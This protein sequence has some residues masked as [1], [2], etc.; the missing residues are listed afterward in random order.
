M[1]RLSLALPWAAVVG[2]WAQL[3][4]RELSAAWVYGGVGACAVGCAIVGTRW[5]RGAPAW[6]SLWVLCALSLGMWAWT[7]WR[8]SAMERDRWG[9]DQGVRD[10]AVVATVEGLPVR[11]PQSLRFLLRIETAHVAGVPVRVPQ[12]VM[13]SWHG[14]GTQSMPLVQAGERWAMTLRLR[15]VHGA[16]NPHGFDRE[17]WLWQ[18]GVGATATVRSGGKDP[19]AQRLASAPWGVDRARQAVVRAIEDRV[20]DPRVGGVLRALVVGEQSAIEREDWAVFRTTGVAHLMSISGLHV[21]MFAWMAMHVLGWV[22]RR[23]ADVWPAVL[24]AWPSPSVAAWGGVVL[25]AG[26]AVFAGWGLPAQRTVLMLA[27]VVAL[28]WSARPWPWPVVWSVAMWV[29]VCWDPWALLQA[30]FWLS[31]VAVGLLMLSAQPERSSAEPS[32]WRAAWRG[33]RLMVREQSLMTV[34]LV[35]L[36][37][38]WFA[39]VTWVSWFAN[40]IAIPWVT[41]LVTPLGLLGVVWSPMWD[42]AAW[43]MG[44]LMGVLSLMAEWPWAA[45]MWAVPPWPLALL[46]VLGGAV[47]VMPWPTVVRLLGLFALAPALSFAPARPEAGGFELVALD[48][49]QGSAVVVRTARHTLL[50]DTGPAYGPGS[51]AGQS[52][53]LPYLWAHGERLDA[54]VVSHADSDHAGGAAAVARAFPSARWLSSFDDEPQRRCVAGQQWTWDGVRFEVVHPLPSD[55]GADGRGRLSSNAMSCV[56]MVSNGAQRAWL[57]G[58]IDAAHETRWALANPE[59]RADVMLAPHHGSASSSSPVLLNTLRP[60]WVLVQAGYLNRWGHPVPAVVAR[61]EQRGMAWQATPQCGATTWR[62]AQSPSVQ[63]HRWVR[64]RYW[65]HPPMG[66]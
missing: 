55:Y 27:V 33:L 7:G 15:P 44:V 31:F 29:V 53:V 49:G 65:H 58:D 35:P 43:A 37:L 4:Q 21:T 17:L 9:P 25:A 61:Y 26:Y 40:L 3:Q 42:A 66:P 2:V 18:H 32:L 30:G 48:V 56:L 60:R 46:A 14:R 47:S 52:V 20:P 51:D 50:Y 54:V 57:G 1:A 28:R 36:T 8:A 64:Q 41:L 23:W 11:G 39:Q 10:V 22:W 5:V 34:A 38:W 59:V 6:R 13:A 24:L 62:S 45:S 19:I 12:R 16:A 63:C